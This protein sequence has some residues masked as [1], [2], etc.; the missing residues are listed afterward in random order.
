MPETSAT[1]RNGS[2]R[3]TA[4]WLVGILMGILSLLSVWTLINTHN[5]CVNLARLEEKVSNL[6]QTLQYKVASPGGSVC[7]Y[8]EEVS[9]NE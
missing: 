2:F 7:I 8:T 4:P 3:I 5:T 1:S 6:E 9:N